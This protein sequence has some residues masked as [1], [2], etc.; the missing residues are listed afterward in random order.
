MCNLLGPGGAAKSPGHDVRRTLETDPDDVVETYG[1][2]VDHVSRGGVAYLSFLHGDPAASLVQGLRKR[3]VGPLVLN[4]GFTSVTT[5]SDASAMLRN[6]GAD[7]VAVGRA[8]IAN[9][10]LVE[11]WRDGCA[12]NDPRPKPF[13]LV[14]PR[15]MSTIPVVE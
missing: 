14:A 2:L 3:I 9:H 1:T 13:T 8:A 12:L 5:L 15:G 4:N 10:D 6:A 7:A 11:R